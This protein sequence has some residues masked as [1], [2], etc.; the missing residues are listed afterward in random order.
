MDD[1]AAWQRLCTLLDDD[2]HLWPAVA[3]SL[4]DP[5]GDAF[6]ALIGGLDDAG[7]LAYLDPEDTGM[8]LADALAQLP[9]VFRLQLDLGVVTDTDDLDEAIALA[10][11]T[12]E[13]RGFVLVRLDEPDEDA[14]AL[15]AVPAGGLEEILEIA[16]DLEVGITRAS[17]ADS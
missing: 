3:E 13:A 2:E 12:L 4:E 9:R 7:V 6:E 15:V 8:E 1:S 10:D 14:H 11:Q 16:G 5:D 17:S